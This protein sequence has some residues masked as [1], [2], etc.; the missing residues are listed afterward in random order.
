MKCHATE[1]NGHLCRN[2][3]KFGSYCGVHCPTQKTK[4]RMARHQ[5]K[6]VREKAA[7]E[8]VVACAREIAECEPMCGSLRVA[9]ARYDRIKGGSKCPQS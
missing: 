3:A 8:R 9:L 7:L 4:R 2:R 1:V 6:P 5:S